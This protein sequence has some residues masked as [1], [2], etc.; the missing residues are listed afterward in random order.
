MFVTCVKDL[1]LK[2]FEEDSVDEMKQLVDYFNGAM[3]R[4]AEIYNCNTYKIT[5]EGKHDSCKA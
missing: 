4:T 1:M 3:K 5:E 2:S